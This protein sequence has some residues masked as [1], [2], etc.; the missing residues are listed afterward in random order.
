[1]SLGG[2]DL[3]AESGAWVIFGDEAANSTD[4]KRKV[5]FINV[6]LVSRFVEND[7]GFQAREVGVAMGSKV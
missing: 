1:M 3:A 4:G 6:Y 7:P 2:M 5:G